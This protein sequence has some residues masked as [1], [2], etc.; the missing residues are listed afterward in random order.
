MNKRKAGWASQ[1]PDKHLRRH[2][3]SYRPEPSRG[4]QKFSSINFR[5]QIKPFLFLKLPAGKLGNMNNT[6]EMY[7]RNTHTRQNSES[8][9]TI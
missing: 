2:V 9:S 7:A 4:S 1:R 6:L 8:P 5:E 3:D